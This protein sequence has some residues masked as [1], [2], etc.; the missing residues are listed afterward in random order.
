M[1]LENYRNVDTSDI[2]MFEGDECAV[3][4]H[5]DGET[6]VITTFTSGTSGHLYQGSSMEAARESLSLDDDEW[7]GLLM[8]DV[9]YL[10]KI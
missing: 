5:W 2:E 8:S 9:Q 7:N 10:E 4:I 1:K 3:V 6:K